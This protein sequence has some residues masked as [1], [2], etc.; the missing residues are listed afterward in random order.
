MTFRA[1][2]LATPVHAQA[3]AAQV[4]SLPISS[5]FRA[6]CQASSCAQLAL[7]H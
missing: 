2:S 1:S 6:L 5:S 7:R 4:P 3:L